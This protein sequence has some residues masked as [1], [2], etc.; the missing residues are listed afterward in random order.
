MSP[1]PA[2]LIGCIVGVVI[3]A[4]AWW[5]HVTDLC[6]EVEAR[7]ARE[8]ARERYL[9]ETAASFAAMQLHAA[10]DRMEGDGMALAADV[11]RQVAE[12]VQ[13]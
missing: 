11:L 7:H 12:E 10:A 13:G 4:V 2:A 1:I 8:I 5:R 3:T 6:A 9:A